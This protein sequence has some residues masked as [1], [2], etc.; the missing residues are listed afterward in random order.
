MPRLTHHARA[1][2]P[3]ARSPS[4]SG[5]RSGPGIR[6]TRRARL[7]G[8][9]IVVVGVLV[10]GLATSF[11]SEP[12]A[13]PA[14]QAFLLDWQQQHYTAAGSLTSAAPPPSPRR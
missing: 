8:V 5:H 7:I 4:H 9:L 2:A 1:A 12:S 10:I 14:A 3:P 6:L 13:E 11:G